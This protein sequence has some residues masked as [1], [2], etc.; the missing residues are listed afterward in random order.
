MSD[1]EE[2]LGRLEAL[3]RA[4]AQLADPGHP[5]GAEA[6]QV[7]VPSTG[8]S[9][10]G[11]D[12]ALRECLEHRTQRSAL[13]QLAR[14]APT[15]SRVHV[16]LSANVF[17]AAFRAIAV[18]LAQS[19]HVYVRPSR[20]EPEMTRLLHR[21]SGGAFELVDT[22]S[23][24]P[25]EHLW[26]YG[27]DQT[28]AR[29]KAELP[30]GVLLHAH[31]AGLGVAVVGRDALLRE[32]FVDDAADRLARDIVAFDQ[33]GC[34]SP[35]LTLVDGD[36]RQAESFASALARALARYE[37]AIPRGRLTQ[38]EAADFIRYRDTMLY[39]ADTLPAG[40]GLV[41]LDPVVDRL[42]VP[43][44]GR[45]M[46]VTQVTSADGH[47]QALAQR[48]TSVGI[49]GHDRLEGVLRTAVGERR[50]VPLGQMQTPPLDGPTD[51]RVGWIAE[52]L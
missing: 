20:R 23:P 46:H 24:R 50:Y 5:L 48:V 12:Y 41:V 22:L 4:A 10:A 42:Q 45:V 40:K 33:R 47:V 52:T 1:L 44:V 36:R 17:V 13:S 25:G 38:D 28:L 29:L 34:L 18:A 16:L 11:V 26:A 35:R 8:L 37:E 3:H 43:P 7:L 19:P 15:A 27:T 30:G 31:G 6:R 14:R 9:S 32:Q 21:A 39:A 2:R 49:A 51:L